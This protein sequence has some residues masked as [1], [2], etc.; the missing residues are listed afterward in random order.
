MECQV[1]SCDDRTSVV[2]EIVEAILWHLASPHPARAPFPHAPIGCGVMLDEMSREACALKAPRPTRSL[3]RTGR[4]VD[5]LDTPVPLTPTSRLST[6][7]VQ[8]STSREKNPRRVARASRTAN[9]EGNQRRN[10]ALPDPDNRPNRCWLRPACGPTG[11]CSAARNGRT[12][13]ISRWR[14]GHPH[15]QRRLCHRCKRCGSP[16]PAW[17]SALGYPREEQ[18]KINVGY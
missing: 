7:C 1:N 14:K 15:S 16:S 9:R 8:D 12:R 4:T 18:I 10:A 17:L 3:T 6:G 2:F 13:S 5:V 11:G